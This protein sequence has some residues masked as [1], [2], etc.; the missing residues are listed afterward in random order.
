MKYC[1][2]IK[3]SSLIF[4]YLHYTRFALISSPFQGGRENYRTIGTPEIMYSCRLKSVC[5]RQ[6]EGMTKCKPLSW[7]YQHVG[8]G[9]AKHTLGCA[10][11]LGKG[12]DMVRYRRRHGYACML[13]MVCHNG[14]AHILWWG[15]RN[16]LLEL[17]PNLSSCR[18]IHDIH[19][20]TI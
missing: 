8:L 12:V 13:H 17:C 1:F 14:F 10:T 6:L 9:E 19:K 4:V 18:D 11:W 15:G 20:S 5:G 7:G 3:L 16:P 2:V